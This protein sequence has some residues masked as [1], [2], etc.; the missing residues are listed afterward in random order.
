M[1]LEL[2]RDS[3]PSLRCGRSQPVSCIR[4]V[5]RIASRMK[6]HPEARQVATA[7]RVA[8]MW[9]SCGRSLGG[10]HLRT[11]PTLTKHTA[12]SPGTRQKSVRS[13]VEPIA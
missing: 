5:V 13:A 6:G 7:Q 9:V 3:R 4:R 11:V 12:S 1:A 10:R 2:D 8:R